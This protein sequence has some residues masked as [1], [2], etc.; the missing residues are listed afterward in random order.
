MVYTNHGS[1][2]PIAKQTT[3]STSSTIRLNLRVVRASEYIQR[4][5]NI[6]FRHKPGA[7]HIVPDALSR[8]QPITSETDYLEGE[9]D[10]LQAHA[11][12]VTA[13]VEMSPELKTRLLEG[14]ASDP[15]WA[16]IA[17]VLDNNENTGEDAAKLLFIRGNNGLF[18]R[19]KDVIADYIYTPQRL[20]I[21]NIYVHEFLDITHLGGY[22]GRDK[23][24]EIITRQQFILG[25]DRKLREYIRY[26]PKYQLYQTQRYQLYR[27]L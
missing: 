2:L 11:Y 1:A 19:I 8:L 12:T 7:Q 23:C 9:L 26:Y 6:E 17:E 18:Q 3:L 20:Y 13:L 21:P 15:K 10:S 14:Y 16:K 25:L 22:V 24:H 27:A 5:R 4:F